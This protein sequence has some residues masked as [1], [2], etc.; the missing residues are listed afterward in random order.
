VAHESVPFAIYAFLHHRTF[1]ET[2]VYPAV[3]NSEDRDTVGA[4]SV[5]I[6][7]AYLG[8]SAI[9]RQLRENRERLEA[10]SRELWKRF[11]Q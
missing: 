10:L 3:L 5:A 9:S 1:F 2:C 4:M 11:Q 8:I 7:G 6:S